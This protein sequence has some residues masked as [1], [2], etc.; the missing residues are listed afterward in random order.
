MGGHATMCPTAIASVY[1][2]EATPES[3]ELVFLPGSRETAFNAHDPSCRGRLPGAHFRA[4][5]GDVTLHFGDTVHAAP[6]P[7]P[8]APSY[9]VSAI[10]GYARP[11]AFHHRGDASY[12]DA[13][14]RRDDGQ[15]DH[16]VDLARRL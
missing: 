1:L 11:G 10:V 7:A 14:H 3:G 9:R 13:L 5:P 6:P 8:G 12:N 2:T 16:L 4:Q 15:V